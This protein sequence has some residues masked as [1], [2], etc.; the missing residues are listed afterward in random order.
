M[1][2]TRLYDIAHARA[3]DKGETTNIGVFPYRAED[4]AMLVRHLTAERVA[5]HFAY[6]H[7]DSVTRYEVPNIGGLNFVL[8]GT[9]RGGVSA[10]LD[11]DSH[12]KSLSFVLLALELEVD[13][14]F[15]ATLP[16]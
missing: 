15:A 10:A 12:G 14:E 8:V 5:A 9:R 16:Q 3:G 1:A 7:L 2:V 11:L 4:Y 13:E 6:M